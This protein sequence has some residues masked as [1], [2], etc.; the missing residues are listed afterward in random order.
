MK[1]WIKRILFILKNRGKHIR[2][3]KKAVFSLANQFTGYNQLGNNTFFV[4]NLGYASYMGSNCHIRADIGRYCCIANG[5]TTTSGTHPTQDWVCMHPA[6]F[7]TQKQCGFSYVTQNL[8]D[9]TTAPVQ[10]GNDVWIGT[11]ATLLGGITI[12]DGAIIAAGAVVTKDVAPYSIVGGVPAKLIK[13]RFDEEDIQFLL[14][15]RWWEKSEDWIRTHAD[16]F[17]DIKTFKTHV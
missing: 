3:G 17:A 15:F 7:S 13:M 1:N 5:V 4:G 10:I 2:L 6:F 9:E 12:G 8:F 11:N 14:D 16:L